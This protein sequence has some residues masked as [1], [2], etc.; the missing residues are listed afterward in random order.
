M[1]RWSNSPGR[2]ATAECGYLMES[3][4][5]DIR[6]DVKTNSRAV[7]RQ[8]RRAGLKPG[9]RVADLDCN[10]LRLLFITPEGR[11]AFCG[12]DVLRRAP[13]L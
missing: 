8:A 5:G 4:A 3:E 13:H 12:G 2:E 7:E 11:T 6:L 9:M 10:C 1:G